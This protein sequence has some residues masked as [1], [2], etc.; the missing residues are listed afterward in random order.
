LPRRSKP[1]VSQNNRRH[2]R[3]DPSG[4][5]LRR[6]TAGGAR[7]PHEV[8]IPESAAGTARQGDWIA[9][10]TRLPQ[11]SRSTTEPPAND[12]DSPVARGFGLILSQTTLLSA[13]LFY[14]GW[15]R[16]RATYAYLGVDSSLLG[17]GVSDY[18]LRSINSAFPFVVFTSV[19]VLLGAA[20]HRA[21]RRMAV[22][23]H[24]WAKVLPKCVSV[25][26]YLALFCV[27]VGVVVRRLQV[28]FGVALPLL[29][30]VGSVA[31]LWAVH[32]ARDFTDTVAS[33][34]TRPDVVALAQ[35]SALLVLL[36]VGYFWAISINAATAG[37]QIAQQFERQLSNDPIVVVFSAHPLAIS[38]TGVSRTTIGTDAAG[39]RYRYDGLCILVATHGKYF[40][41]PANWIR[42][43]DRIFI[44]GES[45][46][47]RIDVSIRTR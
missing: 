10:K 25:G 14:F 12:H 8:V 37:R 15:I 39:F 38:G 32:M 16:T 30:C 43:R 3:A 45:D 19:A 1:P 21:V 17:Y 9:A 5:K 6:Q 28:L 22:T 42:G 13:A 47:I 24:V 31:A 36:V 4:L 23:G 33:Q 7:Q 40:L 11:E 35:R 20:F 46:T 34:P 41:W 29:L 44:I 18:V 2:K 26:G 27:T